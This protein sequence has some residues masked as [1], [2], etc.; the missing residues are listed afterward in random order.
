MLLR[1]MRVSHNDEG[2]QEDNACLSEGV[3]AV[4]VIA[5][6]VTFPHK[7]LRENHWV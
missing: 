6:R 2:C 7:L 3:I 4:C 5:S 1:S